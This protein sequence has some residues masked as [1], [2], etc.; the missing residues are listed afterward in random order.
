[1]ANEEHLKIL[2]EGVNAWN[3]WR[4]EHPQTHPDLSG[5]DFV[6]RRLS[7][8][9]L[10]G[11]N[12]RKSNF[13]E[14]D[15]SRADLSGAVLVYANLFDADIRRA[16]LVEAN[17]TKA[18]LSIANLSRATGGP[19]GVFI[20]KAIGVSD[21]D[22]FINST[23][24]DYVIQR[25]RDVHIQDS[26]VTIVL[27][28]DCAHS[29]RYIDWEIKASLTQGVDRLPNGLIAIQLLSSVNGADLPARLLKNWNAQH[30]NCF[31]RY[32]RY[33]ASREVLRQWIE[34]AFEAKRTRS[35]WI[36]NPQEMMKYNSVCK[37][38]RFTH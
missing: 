17:L 20:P 25:I 19:G 5:A 21:K 37:V 7:Q 28:G 33:P 34:D 15:L 13:I 10:R 3:A 36:Q 24:T 23:N 30:V 4:Y 2:K 6:G 9:N 29:R 22:D 14:A 35:K 31:G 1:M 26:T 27:V 11:A 16:Q 18:D 38:H 32:W 8:V 12:L